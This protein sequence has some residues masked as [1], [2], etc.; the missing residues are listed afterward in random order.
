[1]PSFEQTITAFKR[2]FIQRHS[3]FTER[4]KTVWVCDGPWVSISFA[5]GSA[6]T[7]STVQDLRDFVAKSCWIGNFE[8]PSWLAG[9]MID[10]RRLV[11]G[12][13]AQCAGGAPAPGA[14]GAETAG[15]EADGELQVKKLASSTLADMLSAYGMSFDGREHSGIDDAHNAA[16]LLVELA[17]RGTVLDTN[18]TV[19]EY[20]G[21][22]RMYGWMR[23]RSRRQI[24]D[25]EGYLRHHGHE[26]PQRTD[27]PNLKSSD[28]K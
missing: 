9:D 15:E 11:Q 3:L 26:P 20:G 19:L 8:R 2:D 4:C 6:P 24:V 22:E 25:W 5:A 10:L 7:D 27:T 1:M 16:R 17:R 14:V 13:R 12:A 21:K 23:R 28:A 18:R